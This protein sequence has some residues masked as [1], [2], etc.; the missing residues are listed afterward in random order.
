MTI[1]DESD[2][3]LGVGADDEAAKPAHVAQSARTEA[4][5]VVSTAADGAREV[6]AEVAEQAKAVAN[7]AKEQLQQLATRAACGNT[8]SGSTAQRS[9][10]SPVAH[11]F[12]AVDGSQRWPPG[13]RGIARGCARGRRETSGGVGV[14]CR[15]EGTAGSHGRCHPLGPASARRVPVRCRRCWLRRRS[16][17]SSRGRD[18]AS[19]RRAAPGAFS[20]HRHPVMSEM[21]SAPSGRATTTDHAADV[22]GSTQPKRADAS[23]GDLAAELSEEISTLFRKEVELAKTE[24]TRGARLRRQGRGVLR[25]RRSRRLAGAAAALARLGVV[26][27]PGTEHSALVLDRRRLWAIAAIVFQSAARTKLAGVRGLP[28]TKQTIKEDVQWA[29]AQQN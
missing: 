17:A 6:T 28:Q 2:A 27:R 24:A 21:T 23:L 22:D 4:S 12:G 14:A 29:R 5:E 15:A 11:P 10:G 20:D 26:A 19:G 16:G 8:R 9:G 13:E 18:S 7:D 25:R 1:Q 3:R